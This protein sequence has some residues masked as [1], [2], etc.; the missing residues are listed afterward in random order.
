MASQLFPS[1]REK[2]ATAQLSWI[3]STYRAI[4]LPEAFVPDFDDVFLSDIS[5]G[6]RIATSQEITDRTATGGKCSSA[7]ILFGVLADARLG[8]KMIIY[9]DTLDETTS[10]LV[11]FI[12][13]AQI[14]G[15]PV[16][17]EG[18]EYF[19][20]PSLLDGGIFRL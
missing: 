5:A 4:L 14:Q 18:L 6:V 16:T 12:D 19:F 13:E 10:D 17:L 2:F 1:A 8:D 11:V 20:T 7:P 15:A 9:R 3:A